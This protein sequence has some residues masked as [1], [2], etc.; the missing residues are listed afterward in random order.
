MKKII[1]TAVLFISITSAFSQVT[2]DT[3]VVNANSDMSRVQPQEPAK[4]QNIDLTN[5]SNDHF[6]LQYGFDNWSGTNDSTSPSGFSRHFN[7][8]FMLDKPFKSNPKFSVGIGAGIGSSNIFFENKG[9]DLKSGSARLP[10]T[11]LDSANH[12][13]KYKLTT[14]YLEARVE[15]RY[16]SNPLNSNKSFKMAL[17]LKVGTMVDAHTKGKTLV[18]KA[19]NTVNDFIMKEKSKRFF[20]STKLAVTGGLAPSQRPVIARLGLRA[21]AAG[22]LANLMSAALA[23]VMLP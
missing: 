6:M 20:N 2:T 9:I 16:N 22:S 10:F 19:G 21:L 11:N 15:L 4:W 3:T 13:K 1:L 7:V 23:S 5:R 14:V 17:G 18:D 12:F 8:Y